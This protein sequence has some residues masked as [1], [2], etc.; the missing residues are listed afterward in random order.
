MKK[1]LLSAPVLC[2]FA[3]VLLITGCKKD[4]DP[5]PS[6]EELLVEQLSTNWVV[7]EARVDEVD[8]KDAVE[9]LTLSLTKEKAYSTTNSVAPIWPASGT[10]TVV[11]GSAVGA[12]MLQRNDG[13]LISILS[14]SATRL[15]LEFNYS[16]PTA[17]TKQVSGNYKFAFAKK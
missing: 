9:N 6:E 4:N 15:Q 11:A 12:F 3:I 13:V 17:R 2:L 7:S 14:V 8:V 10:F 1:Q 5:K 16:A